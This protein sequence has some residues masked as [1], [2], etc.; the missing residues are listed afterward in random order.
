MRAGVSRRRWARTDFRYRVRQLNDIAS[1][2]AGDLRAVAPL[3]ES[4]ASVSTDEVTST[5]E[6]PLSTAAT[7]CM[8]TL[9]ISPETTISAGKEPVPSSI[10]VPSP[11][12]EVA[13]VSENIRAIFD[14]SNQISHLSFLKAL[15]RQ[16]SFQN[17]MPPSGTKSTAL[18]GPLSATTS[19]SSN[20]PVEFSAQ[21]VAPMPVDAAS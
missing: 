13:I 1:I 5:T 15:I 18:P 2:Y 19:S 16:F 20:N 7:P 4:A 10:H 8:G 12:T 14:F 3:A 6:A 21:V 11:S 17:G 9:D